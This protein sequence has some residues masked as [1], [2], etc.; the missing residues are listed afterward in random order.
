ME[1]D[2]IKAETSGPKYFALAFQFLPTSLRDTF[3]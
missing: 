1:E 3:T 2:G